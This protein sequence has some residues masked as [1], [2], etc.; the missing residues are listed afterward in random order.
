M[1]VG[2]HAFSRKSRIIQQ[3]SAFDVPWPAVDPEITHYV[4]RVAQ[5]AAV[6]VFRCRPDALWSVNCAQSTGIIGIDERRKHT[7]C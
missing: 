5:F 7:L 3:H 4:G 1:G 2:G 6:R